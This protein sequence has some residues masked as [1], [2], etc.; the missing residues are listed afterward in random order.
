MLQSGGDVGGIRPRIKRSQYLVDRSFGVSFFA[1]NL[2]GVV[3]GTS[4]DVVA[5][6]V[7]IAVGMVAVVAVGMATNRLMV[8]TAVAVVG[9]GVVAAVVG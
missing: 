1:V 4:V 7:A 2:R 5:E 6:V 3:M 8:A 9:I